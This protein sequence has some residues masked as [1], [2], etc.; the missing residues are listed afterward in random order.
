MEGASSSVKGGACGGT[1]GG[2]G[3]GGCTGEGAYM[4]WLYEGFQPFVDEKPS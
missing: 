1:G 3:G 2:G 4:I